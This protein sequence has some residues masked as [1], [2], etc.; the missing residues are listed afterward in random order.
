MPD[1]FQVIGAGIP[2]WEVTHLPVK[3]A[4]MDLLD[5]TLIDPENWTASYVITGHLVAALRGQEEFRTAE[6]AEFIREGREEA[7]NW[8]ARRSEEALEET[9]AG[10]PVQV[11]SRLWRV[12]KTGAWLVVQP[13]TV[14]GT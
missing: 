12:T 5:L 1:L 3:Q 10:A 11:A 6:H 2:G 9:L 14:N 13:S 7:R 8:N 4:G